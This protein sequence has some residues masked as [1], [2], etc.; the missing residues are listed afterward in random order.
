MKKDQYEFSIIIPCRNRCDTLRQVLVALECQTF[1][2]RAFQ[3]IVIDDQ[4]TDGTDV[5]LANFQKQTCLNLTALAGKGTT[6]GAARNT[7]LEKACGEQILFLD[8]DTI[9]HKNLLIQHQSWQHHFGDK[10]CI[11]GRVCMSESLKKAE[12]S[13]VNEA[14]TK[15]DKQ[16]TAELPW[17]E[18]RTANTSI[19]RE[20]CLR[21]G[22]FDSRLPAAEDTE[23]ASRLVKLGVRFFFVR[24]IEVVHHHPMDEKGYFHKGILYGRAIALWYRKAPEHRAVLVHRYGVYAPELKKYRKV[25]HIFRRF[26][27]NSLSVPILVSTARFIRSTWFEMSNH[28]YKCVYRYYVRQAFRSS[29]SD[30]TTGG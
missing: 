8:A 19:A 17:P 11:V 14:A 2:Q 27:I 16:C 13:R 26:F 24:D 22:G 30:I 7:G 12:Q 23:F 18:Y 4:S 5:F 25:K 20:I 9:P 3:V 6:A 15:Y 29:L 21:A 1:P 10:T 28:V